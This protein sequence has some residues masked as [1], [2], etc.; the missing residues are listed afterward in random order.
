MV[1]KSNAHIFVAR[2]HPKKDLKM[3]VPPY[4]VSNNTLCHRS[5]FFSQTKTCYL[6]DDLPGCCYYLAGVAQQQ[7][8]QHQAIYTHRS[9][10]VHARGGASTRQEREREM[11]RGTQQLL[12]W[13]RNALPRIALSSTHSMV[14]CVIQSCIH[15]DG[16]FERECGA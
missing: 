8:Q 4:G 2:D 14:R 11:H 12:H 13:F 3:C 16:Y 5:L 7:Q 9:R 10:Y 15:A 1:H 6:K